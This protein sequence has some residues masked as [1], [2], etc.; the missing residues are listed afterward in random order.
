[1]FGTVVLLLFSVGLLLGIAWARAPFR[2]LPEALFVCD[3][4]GYYMYLPSIVID[5]DLDFANEIA[6]HPGQLDHTFYQVVPATGLPANPFPVGCAVIWAPVFL[7]AHLFWS[8][9]HYLGL[10]V[11]LDGY[12]WGYELPVYVA[13][14]SFGLLGVWYLHRLLREL[15]GGQVASWATGYVVLASATA[16]YLWFEPDMSH[17]VSMTV[18]A[19]LTYYL[20]RAYRENIRRWTY[21]AWLGLLMGLVILLRPPNGLVGVAVL[22]VGA[23]I[24]LADRSWRALLQR[25]FLQSL[26]ACVLVTAICL[27]PQLLVWKI[28]FGSYL[29]MPTGT[30]YSRIHWTTPHL[31]SF[32][33]STNHGLFSWTPMILIAVVGLLLGLRYG[34][35]ALKFMLPVLVLSVYFN[36]AMPN[37][38]S[39]S[40]FGQRRMVD[41]TVLFALGLG[42]LFHCCPWLMSR[43]GPRVVGMVLIAFNWVLIVRYF[44]RQMAEMGEITWHDL[45]VGTAAFPF[46]VVRN[47]LTG[48][49]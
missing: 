18:I 12:G 7:L 47:Y 35:P 6:A 37:W 29:A 43:W 27:V 20:H 30:T 40:S 3:G 5:G 33:F 17:I 21:W 11:R 13:S 26:A 16:A 15:W 45:I 31:W 4:F 25:D 24:F 2:G 46:V 19:M 22:W 32:L 36:S 48:S 42:Y 8:V 41:F 49:A 14:F 38:W 28:L 34:P 10:P 9:L 1:V 39:D 23:H 44:S